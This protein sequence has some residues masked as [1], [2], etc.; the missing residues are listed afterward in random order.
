MS[1]SKLDQEGTFRCDLTAWGIKLPGREKPEDLSPDDSAKWQ[2]SRSVGIEVEMIVADEY[3]F[4]AKKWDTWRANSKGEALPP[5]K[6]YGTIYIIGR[7]GQENPTGIEHAVDALK[8]DGDLSTFRAGSVPPQGL[9]CVVTTSKKEWPPKSGK[10]PCKVDWWNPSTYT[11]QSG[12]R[13]VASDAE[14]QKL[15]DEMGA[16]L[17]ASAS[18]KK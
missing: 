4:V 1:V 10:F 12:L 18:K 17:R 6:V 5:V 7:E 8:W 13:N 11:P 14:I 3:D 16:R 15:S 9:Q 2:P